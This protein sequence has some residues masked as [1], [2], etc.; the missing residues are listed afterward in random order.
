MFE[1]ELDLRREKKRDASDLI[2]CQ[3]IRI[4]IIYSF[5]GY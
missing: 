3:S 4:L 5:N 1:F 2:N